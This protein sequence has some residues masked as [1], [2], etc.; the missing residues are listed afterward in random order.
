MQ[1][2]VFYLIAAFITGSITS[3]G[4]QNGNSLPSTYSLSSG[5][6]GLDVCSSLSILSILTIIF[7]CIGINSIEL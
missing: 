4:V 1:V 5:L 7:F 6:R 3:L 2:Y